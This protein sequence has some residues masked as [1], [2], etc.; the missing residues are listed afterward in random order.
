MITATTWTILLATVA[1]LVVA[2]TPLARFPG[3][4]A[5]SS[6]L[7]I[8]VVAVLASQSNFEGI[9][10]A[11]LYLLCGV[12]IIAIHAVLLVLAARAVPFRPVPVRHLVAGAHRRRRRD[13]CAR[14]ELRAGPGAGRRPARAAGLYPRDRLRPG[15]GDSAV[16][17][18]VLMS[19]TRHDMRAFLLTTALALACAAP[20]Q[21][22]QP[23]FTPT[24]VPPSGVIG[25]QDA[26]LSP[27]F[28]IARQQG[29]DAIVMD[30]AAIDAQNARLMRIDASM[31]DLAA[32]PATLDR[33]QV[34]GVDRP[35]VAAAGRAAVRCAGSKPST[36]RHSMPS[37]PTPTAMPCRNG[38]R[39]A[40]A[41]SCVAPRCARSRRRLR[42]FT[43]RGDTDIDRFQESA[44]FPGTPV[45]IV[46]ASRDGQLAVRR[47]PALRG[48]GR[49]RTP[50]PKAPGDAVLGYADAAPY[51]LV[52]GAKV[53]TV[54]TPEEPRVSELQLDMGVRVPLAQ[55]AGGTP[56][57]GQQPY[58]AWPIGL[59]V[60]NADGSLQPRHRRCCR[61]TPTRATRLPA[62][63]A[64]QHHPPG[65]QVPRR[66]LRL[67]P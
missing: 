10:A 50:L 35:H 1:G 28:W 14:G 32:L 31:H 37:S 21:A 62:A 4:G 56:V 63:D 38:N 2:H 65:V 43:E 60:R 12:S 49:K 19:A 59:P 8:S 16:V 24:T 41:W 29:A 53:R 45:V 44:L 51:R 58:T 64:R 46:H 36:R 20:L 48:V 3:A 67:G 34:A 25:V 42:V 26:Y 23:A 9:A 52:T 47:Q 15:D 40:T 17:A 7:L 5:V 66:A 27:D 54:F 55:L 22:R 11:P 61:R 39:R 13:T 18:G 30:R 57:N 33:A 6:A